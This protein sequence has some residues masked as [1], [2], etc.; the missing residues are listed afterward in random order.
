MNLP[1][2]P[3]DKANHAIYGALIALVVGVVLTR[4]WGLVAAIGMGALKE[5]SDY[6]LNRRAIARGELPPHGV[7][8]Y[9]LIATSLGGAVV[10]AAGA[11]T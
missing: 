4:E 2:L 7:E 5:A 6:A 8:A 9:D 3:Q 11:L 10:Y 1:L